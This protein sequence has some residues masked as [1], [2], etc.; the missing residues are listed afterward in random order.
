M[1]KKSLN[2]KMNIEINNNFNEQNNNKYYC[3]I[4]GNNGDN[5]FEKIK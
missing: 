2:E 5:F 1:R 4:G 3:T